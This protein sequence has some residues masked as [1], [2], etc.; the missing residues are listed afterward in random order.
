M[1]MMSLHST[2]NPKTVIFGFT[3]GSW[4]IYSQVLGHSSS[5]RYAFHLVEWALNHMLVGDSNKLWATFALTYLTGRT[6]L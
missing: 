5:V 2:G 4:P 3:L 6:V 1:V